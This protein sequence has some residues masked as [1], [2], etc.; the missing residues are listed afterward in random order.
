MIFPQLPMGSE[1][2]FTFIAPDSS[3]N[4]EA[5]NP[6]SF[7]GKRVAANKG[8]IQMEL[9]KEWAAENDVKAELIE[10]TSDEVESEQMLIDGKF[11]AFITLDIYADEGKAIP[12]TKIGSSDY[13][14]AINKNRPELL[15]EIDLITRNRMEE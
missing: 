2:Y 6:S 7:N 1:E 12:V 9:F 15:P 4:I 14:F 8:S 3:S 10:L 13:Y 11:D 5:N